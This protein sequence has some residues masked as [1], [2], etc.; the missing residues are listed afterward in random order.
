MRFAPFLVTGLL[1]LG[2]TACESTL[3][4]DGSRLVDA[5]ALV[6]DVETRTVG[7]NAPLPFRFANESDTEV[8]TGALDCVVTYER[9]DG[10]RW[11]P[12]APLRACI[13]L[14]EIHPARSSR[15]YRTVAPEQDGLWRLVV[16]AWT[17]SGP[18]GH[19]VTARSQAF[20]V[21]ER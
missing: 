20:A 9:R 17:G 15:N 5:S 18:E 16:E 21:V 12:V 6:V 4:D 2:T 3:P 14:A 1:V 7:P 10:D 19:R 8:I 13:A 11:E